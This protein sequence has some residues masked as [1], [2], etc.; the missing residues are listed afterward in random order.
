[1]VKTESMWHGPSEDDEVDG[2]VTMSASGLDSHVSLVNVTL[3]GLN[4]KAGGYHIHQYPLNYRK[5]GNNICGT[6]GGHFN[7]FGNKLMRVIVE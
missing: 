1:M 3:S 4:S 6:T 2:S 5:P 7:P